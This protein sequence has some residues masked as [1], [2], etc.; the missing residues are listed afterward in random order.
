MQPGAKERKTL[1]Q[2]LLL[3]PR[4]RFCVHSLSPKLSKLP[5]EIVKLLPNFPISTFQYLFHAPIRHWLILFMLKKKENK[6]L[7][8]VIQNCI[9]WANHLVL[10]DLP[11]AVHD[12]SHWSGSRWS[13]LF[14]DGPVKVKMN[15]TPKEIRQ[16]WCWPRKVGCRP[17]DQIH[18]MWFCSRPVHNQMESNLAEK[19][20]SF[21]S[22]E[23]Q[24]NGA[25]PSLHLWNVLQ[26][27]DVAKVHPLPLRLPQY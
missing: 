26:M 6:F 17:P 1:L 10:S 22:S 3:V 2:L 13:N 25:E 14:T 20:D 8:L 27:R 12:R 9:A 11:L 19:L 18:V 16:R 15:P 21:L 4:A 7:S 5:N 23:G 24:L